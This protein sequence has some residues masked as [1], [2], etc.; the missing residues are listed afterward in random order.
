MEVFPEPQKFGQY[1]LFAKVDQGGMAEVFLATSTKKELLGQFLAIKKLHKAL[2]SNKPFVNLLIHEAKIGVLLN[3]PSVAQVYDLGSFQ[4]E[5][6]IAMEYVH[7]KSL[8][9]LLERIREKKAPPLS[10]EIASYIIFET[11]RA[12]A[13]AHQ[14]KDIKGRDLNIIHRDVTPGNILLEYKGNIKLT[15]FGIATAESR[16]QK[17]FTKS[18]MG[19]KIYMPPEQTVNDPVVRSSDLYSLTLVYFELL[20]GQLPFFSDSTTDLYKKIVDGKAQDI[21]VIMPSIKEDLAKIIRRGMDPSAKRRY[22]DAPEYFQALYQYFLTEEKIDFQSR[23]TRSYYRKKL[24]EYL[25]KNFHEEIV[26]EIQLIQIAL[27]QSQNDDDLKA[28]APQQ[29]PPELLED[30]LDGVDEKTVFYE[31]NTNEATRNFPLTDAER[32]GI[33]EGLPPRHVLKGDLEDEDE[34][35]RTSGFELA[36][37]ADYEDNFGEKAFDQ[38]TVSDRLDQILLDHDDR[39]QLRDQMPA[40]EIK[41][42]AE[43]DAFEDS[44]LSGKLSEEVSFEAPESAVD[45]MVLQPISDASSN[46]SSSFTRSSQNKTIASDAQ[47]SRPSLVKNKIKNKLGLGLSIGLA[48]ILFIAA[49]YGIV[50]YLDSPPTG[51]FPTKQ[52]SLVFLGEASLSKQRQIFRLLT[53][54]NSV[55][56]FEKLEKVFNRSYQELTGQKKDVLRILAHEPVLTNKNISVDLISQ[57]TKMPNF[58]LQQIHSQ[59]FEIKQASDITI[60]IYFLPDTAP[61]EIKSLIDK[62]VREKRMENQSAIFALAAENATADLLLR[63]G[64][65]IALI[66]GAKDLQDPSTGM[67]LTPE[68]FAEPGKKPLFPQEYAE[69]MAKDIPTG[70]LQE[71]PIERID[72]VIIG[73]TTARNLKWISEKK[74][75]SFYSP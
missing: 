12:L 68:G 62:G 4:T 22:R 58:L 16:L 44:T 24:S 61:L 11:L 5:F 34:K 1:R 14:L 47:S 42:R 46:T 37:I 38:V 31:D 17:D 25:R 19:K 59:G 70:L 54:K 60:F 75:A 72:Q 40:Q 13:F 2:N 56:N 21:R 53:D 9:R 73:P 48:A 10:V 57:K 43:L 71:T 50:K 39:E 55:N 63:L 3:H 52:V 65:E 18:A 69:L 35:E 67:A 15:D 64:R 28:T 51:L 20:S 6:F 33:L 74:E 36:T 45:S 7:G 26:Q 66:Y 49:T 27:D 32:K 30:G 23:T 8:E 29:V 41:T